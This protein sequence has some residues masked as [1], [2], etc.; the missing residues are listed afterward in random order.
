MNITSAA[1]IACAGL[2]LAGCSAD[3]DKYYIKYKNE[4][5]WL[6][7]NGLCGA[8][9]YPEF[10]TNKEYYYEIRRLQ[11]YNVCDKELGLKV[12]K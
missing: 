9:K 4:V 10:E 6:T 2:A 7:D 8:Y 5:K 3:N 12:T 1:L 11:R